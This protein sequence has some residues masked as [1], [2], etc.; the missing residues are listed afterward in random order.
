MHDESSGKLWHPQLGTE[1][2]YVKLYIGTKK[3]ET[4]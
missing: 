4:N 3:K 2:I 1:S